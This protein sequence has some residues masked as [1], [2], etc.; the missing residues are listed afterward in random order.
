MVCIGIDLGTTNSCVGVWQNNRV[1]I[2]ANDQGNRTT[3]SY[4]AFTDEER[5]IGDAAKNQS[6]MNPKNT[7]YDAKRLLGRTYDDEHVQNDMKLWSFDVVND[8]NKPKIQ[9]E[10]EGSPKQFLPE[11]ISAMVLSKMKTIAENYLGTEVKDCVV[12]VPAYFGDSQRQATKDAATIAGLNCLRI[13]NEPTAAAIAYGLD[14]KSTM[15][16]NILIF[17]SGGGTHDISLISIEDGVF[18]VKATDGD[19]HLGG[20]DI[21]ERLVKH[22]INEFK[23][24]Y[25]KDPSENARSVKRLKNSCEKLKRTLS[26]TSQ[27]TLELDGFFDGIDFMA[28]LTRARFEELCMDIFKKTMEPVEN[29][30]KAAKLSKSQIHEIVLVGGTTRIPKIQK[31]LS[32]FFNGKELN[33]SVNPDEAVAYGACVQGAILTGNTD[34]QVS[35]LLLLDVT[36]LSLGIE[37]AGGVMTKLINRNSSIPVTKSQVFSTY[38]DNQTAVTVQVFEG[39]RSMTKDNKLLGQFELSGIPPAPRGTPQIEVSFDIDTN[40][41][42]NVSAVEKSS[43][44]THKIT[45]TNDKKMSKEEIEKLIEESE[46]F[47]ETDEKNKERIEAKNDLENTLYSIKSQEFSHNKEQIMNIITETLSWLDDNQHA[48]KN[49]YIDKLTFVKDQVQNLSQ[50]VSNDQSGPEIVDID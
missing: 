47:K 46:K 39:E 40:G 21:D 1:E 44:N 24:K 19:S 8:N 35:D 37:T 28:T 15:E 6:S 43:G 30:L 10:V 33:K 45:I 16:Q 27:A 36:P 23:R 26:S 2:I 38:S 32:E 34:E 50:T 31:M 12:T 22:F 42:L 3:P 11:E 49:D 4:V 14:K 29:V 20:E 41:I 7:I 17:D 48:D 25:K 13:I 9:V 5:L 18:E